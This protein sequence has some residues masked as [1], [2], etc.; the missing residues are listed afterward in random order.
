[1]EAISYNRG[2]LR[3]IQT[4]VSQIWQTGAARIVRS[5]HEGCLWN[6]E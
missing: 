5:G 4:M 1:M 6:Y 3:D 2:L